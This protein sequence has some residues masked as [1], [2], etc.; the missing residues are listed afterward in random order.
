MIPRT[1]LNAL[2]IGL[3]QFPALALLGPRQS[4]KTTLARDIANQQPAIYL[5]L[6]RDEDLALLTD[7]RLFLRAQRGKLVVIDEVQRSPELF[8]SLRVEIDERR[9]LGE[10]SGHFLLLGSASREL[11]AQ[12]S[13]SL[14]GRIDYV[15]L[16]PLHMGELK[17]LQ[18]NAAW[19]RG[20]YPDSLLAVGEDQSYAWRRAYL[21]QV[22]ERDIPFFSPRI[23]GLTV[24]KLLAMVA[25]QQGG[26]LNASRLAKNLGLSSQTVNR[27]LLLLTELFHLRSLSP[28][29][30][31]ATKRLIKSPKVYVRDSGLLHALLEIPNEQALLRHPIIGASFEGFVIEQATSLLGPSWKYSFY[32]TQHGAEIDLI[33]ERGPDCLAIEIKRASRPVPSA[34]FYSGCE[35]VK[36]THQWVIHAGEQDVSL[37]DGVLAFPWTELT[38]KVKELGG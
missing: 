24:R 34:G 15:E 23:P 13:E 2:K 32:R 8:R 14:A 25:A 30:N 31:N 11:L 28:W 7:A 4:G 18:F 19:S 17:P 33:C 9:L 27:Y 5:D 36:A 16:T 6:E 38:T 20:G 35:M 21:S 12:S 37:G 22:I 29:H 10:K 26:L 3:A 1:A